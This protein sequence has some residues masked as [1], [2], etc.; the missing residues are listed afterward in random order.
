MYVVLSRA[1]A[2]PAMEGL[3]VVFAGAGR[4]LVTLVMVLGAPAALGAFRAMLSGAGIWPGAIDPCPKRF[5]QSVSTH[6]CSTTCVSSHCALVGLHM[7][8][9]RQGYPASTCYVCAFVVL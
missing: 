4:T 7:D 3:R 6:L 1:Q 5:P 2:L 8:S 9:S